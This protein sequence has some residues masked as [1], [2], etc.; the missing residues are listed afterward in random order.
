MNN[1]PAELQG[2]L[3]TCTTPA[4]R[5]VR[6]QIMALSKP[7]LAFKHEDEADG[8]PVGPV[9]LSPVTT[10]TNHWVTLAQAQVIA[11]ALGLQLEEE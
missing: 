11:K 10:P 7:K 5:L 1:L 4:M 3:R 8:E 2:F 6:D 9:W